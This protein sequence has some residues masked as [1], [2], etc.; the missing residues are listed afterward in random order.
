MFTVFDL[1]QVY[2]QEPALHTV[3]ITGIWKPFHTW[4][5]G[6]GFVFYVVTRLIVKTT[7]LLEVEGR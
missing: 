1:I 5:F 2:Y 4:F 6:F 7:K 3:D